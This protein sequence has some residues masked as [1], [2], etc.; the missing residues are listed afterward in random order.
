M[1]RTRTVIGWRLFY[2]DDR[3]YSS[4]QH[5]WDEPPDDGTLVLKLYY[6]A[7][8]GDSD[9]RYTLLL[10]GDDY[11]FHVPDT[12]LYGCSNDPPEEIRERYPGAII[13]RGMWTTAEEFYAVKDRAFHTA[14][15]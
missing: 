15:P 4:A 14:A 10:D 7:M 13:K 5:E 3:H 8:S 6:E 12:N 1:T 2:T 9:E 11:Y